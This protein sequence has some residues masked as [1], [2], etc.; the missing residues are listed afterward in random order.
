MQHLNKIGTPS[1]V[2]NYHME[3]LIENDSYQHQH[4]QNQ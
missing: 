1:F 2:S 3:S 4:L